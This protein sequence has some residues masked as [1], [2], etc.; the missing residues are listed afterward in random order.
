MLLVTGGASSHWNQLILWILAPLFKLAPPAK[1]PDSSD[2]CY[3]VSGTLDVTSGRSRAP[4]RM[5]PQNFH[6]SRLPVNRRGSFGDCCQIHEFIPFIAPFSE[7]F[8]CPL[9]DVF[10]FFLGLTKISSLSN[11]KSSR[12][13]WEW[14]HDP[15]SMVAAAWMRRA[16]VCCRPCKGALD[17]KGTDVTNMKQDMLGRLR[18]QNVGE[19]CFLIFLRFAMAHFQFKKYWRTVSISNTNAWTITAS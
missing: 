18:Y 19:D 3:E 4:D 17:S 6:S 14:D 1:L 16:V 10:S 9:R 11:S 8:H 12:L 5:V 13:D 7:F 2:M 15:S